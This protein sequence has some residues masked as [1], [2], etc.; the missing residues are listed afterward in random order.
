M[1]P[2]VMVLHYFISTSDEENTRGSISSNHQVE[3][4]PTGSL[5]SSG[6]LQDLNAA[7]TQRSPWMTF[8]NGTVTSSSPLT[9]GSTPGQEVFMLAVA[10]MLTSMSTEWITFQI[11][12]VI[13][14]LISM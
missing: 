14:L 13:Y 8:Y 11:F 4:C 5:P 1:C 12:T 7:G 10:V 2:E 6:Q 9:L 3:T